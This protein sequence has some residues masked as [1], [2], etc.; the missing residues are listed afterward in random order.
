VK[1]HRC[2]SKFV[3]FHENLFG[4]N[5]GL[6]RQFNEWPR[7]SANSVHSCKLNGQ[8]SNPTWAIFFFFSL[9]IVFFR[10]LIRVSRVRI[11]H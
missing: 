10:G 9:I 1:I 7:G 3:I 4:V 5:S 8:G 6:R 11:L 2:A